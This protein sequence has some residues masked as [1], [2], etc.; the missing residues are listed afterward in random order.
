MDTFTTATKGNAADIPARS[1]AWLK[2]I[3][4]A[5][6]GAT[7]DGQ[8]RYVGTTYTNFFIIKASDL[9]HQS[10]VQLRVA[11]DGKVYKRDRT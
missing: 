11:P 5:W 3:R 8:D 1:D 9:P 2:T 6:K 10:G 7:A 4:N